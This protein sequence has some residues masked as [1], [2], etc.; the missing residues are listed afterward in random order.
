MTVAIEAPA[1]PGAVAFFRHA[2]VVLWE[3]GHVRTETKVV[4]PSLLAK[5]Y[6]L[7]LW[8]TRR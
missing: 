1:T 8:P 6:P 2:P 3:E 5:G 4:T 7:F